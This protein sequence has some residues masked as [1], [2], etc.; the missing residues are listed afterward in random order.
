MLAAMPG[1]AAPHAPLL[2]VVMQMDEVRVQAALQALVEHVDIKAAAEKHE[3]QRLQ[4]QQ[5]Q[6]KKKQ[7]QTA[8]DSTSSNNSSGATDSKDA[9]ASNAPTE[10]AAED[11]TMEA[12]PTEEETKQQKQALA[13]LVRY[14][15]IPSFCASLSHCDVCRVVQAQERLS[16]GCAVWLYVLLA[17]LDKPIHG[18]TASWLR[19]L[20]RRLA[21]IRATQTA[22]NETVCFANMVLTIV[23]KIFS[24]K[25]L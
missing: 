22:L 10:D 5:Q 20:Y 15:C 23:D 2:H 24:Q 14:C 18:N 7:Q 1:F 9:S 12:A 8:G 17:R 19:S 21:D 4:Q 13:E 16:R 3:Q 6:Q 11:V 25:V